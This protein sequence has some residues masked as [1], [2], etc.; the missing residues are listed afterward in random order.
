M[1]TFL[2]PSAVEDANHISTGAQCAKVARHSDCSSCA[3]QGLHPQPD[4]QAVAD[5]SDDANDVL[6][7]AETDER[8]NDE[9][10]LTICACDHGLE[11]H[12]CDT[13]DSEE[14]G[15]RAALA[16]QIDA[17]LEVCLRS[18]LGVARR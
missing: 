6:A 16:V 7:T 4:W 11:E 13:P 3:C 1:L 18:T 8:L 12:G 5:D 14:F 15:R 10:F 17:I 9:C 2:Y